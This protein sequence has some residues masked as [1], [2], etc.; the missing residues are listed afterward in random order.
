[1]NY[2]VCKCGY[3]HKEGVLASIEH[4]TNC[5][6]AKWNYSSLGGVTEQDIKDLFNAI[7]KASNDIQGK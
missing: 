6:E 5:P 1:M 2:R 4:D 7:Y 3:V